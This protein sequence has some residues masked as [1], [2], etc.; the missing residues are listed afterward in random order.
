MEDEE[1]IIVVSSG[2]GS[3]LKA[4][5][6]TLVVMVM[7]GA[8]STMSDS[9]PSGYHD[10][11]ID[12]FDL[13]VNYNPKYTRVKELSGLKNKIIFKHKVTTKDYIK[14]Y[15]TQIKAKVKPVKNREF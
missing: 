6:N 9:L 14:N 2:R 11:P 4:V 1:K 8:N 7:A 13:S 12:D 5:L 15:N 10:F 3:F